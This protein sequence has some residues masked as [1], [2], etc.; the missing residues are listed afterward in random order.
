MAFSTTARV[1]CCGPVRRQPPAFAVAR[2][3]SSSSAHQQ[4]SRRGDVFGNLSVRSTS[5]KLLRWNVAKPGRGGR[6]LVEAA[7]SAIPKAAGLF[8]PANDKDACG[9]G[10]VGELNREPSRQCVTDALEMMLRMSHRGACGCEEN[11]GDGAGCLV[12]MPHDFLKTVVKK[13]CG[14]DLPEPED[15]GVGMCFLPNA[16]KELYAKAKS[17]ITKV[18]EQ[19][20]H[21]VLGWRSVPTD[22][23][24]IGP[25]AL[26]TQPIVEQIFLGNS[27]QETYCHT[28]AEQQFYILRKLIE[29]ELGEQEVGEDECYICSLSSRILV[30]KGQLTPGQVTTYY[31]D[32]Q[33]PDFKTYMTL[34]HSRFSTNTF[35]SWGRSQPMRMIG[36]NG[37][38]NTL[39][40]N[41]NWMRS[42]EGIMKCTQLGLPE[43]V[44]LKMLPLVPATQSDSG[45]F[46][47]V[48]ELLVNSG[49]DLPEAMM[50]MIP[51]AWQNDKLMPQ[52]KQDFYRFHS[53]IMEPWDGPALVAFTDGRFVGAT[54]D[55][56]GLRPG[57]YYLTKDNRVIMASEVGVVDVAPDNVAYKGRLSPGNIFLVDFAEGRVIAD[58][59]MKEKYANKKPYGKWLDAQVA[60]LPDLVE[61][62]PEHLFKVPTIQ[63]GHSPINAVPVASSSKGSAAEAN[64][65]ANGSSN[66]SFSGSNGTLSSSQ[67]GG[68]IGVNASN[69]HSKPGAES[70]SGGEGAVEQGDQL[71]LG[72]MMGTHRTLQPLKA[73]GYTKEALEVQL[74]PMVKAAAEPLG[75]MG[76]DAPLAAM[77]Q[78]PKL[79]YDYFKQMF[80][81][82]TNPPIDPLREKLVTSTRAMIGPEG[83][84]TDMGHEGHAARLELIQPFLKPEELQA[85]KH[86]DYRGWRAKV[87][88]ATWA[89]SEGPDGMEAGLKR[90]CEEADQAIQEGYSYLIMSDRATGEQRVPISSLLA[91]GRVHHHLVSKKKRMLAGL[92]VESGE[93]RDVH[94]MCTLLGYGAD[95]ICPYLAMEAIVA[96]QEDGKVDG[97]ASRL[98]LIENYIKALNA[99][100]L[101]VMSKM[102]IS[103]IASYKGAQIFE[104]LGM[105]DEVVDA[106]FV[107]TASRIAGVGY[108]TLAED[109]MRVHGM[110]YGSKFMS[111]SM[112]DA[113]A[114]PNPGD[115]HW[116][117]G[118][119]GEQ[120]EVHLNDPMAIAKL[121]EAAA[122]NS[123]EAFKEYVRL[124]EDLNE[125]INLRGMLKFKS[126]GAIPIEEVEPAKEIVKRFVTGAMSYGSISLEAHT[127]L[128]IAMNTIGGKSNTGEG[129]ENLRRLLP[130]PDGSRNM[131]RSAIKQIASGRFGVTANYLTNADELQ[132]KIAQ[133]AK[134]GEGGELPGQ[135]VQGDIART[136]ASTPGVGLISP[137]PHHD[138]YSIE[139]LAQLIYDLK[140]SNPGARVSVKL[141]SENNVGVIASGV[142]KGHAD[143]VL[144]SGHDGGTGAA[145]WTSIKSAG[146]PWELGLA[147]THQ[148]LVAN[149]LRGR[150]TLQADG[151]MRTGKDIAVAALLG[152]EEFGFSTAP[153]ITLGCIMMRKCHTNTCPVGVATQDPV[154]R[155]KFAGEP[156]HAINFFFM[157]AE[158]MRE[159]MAAMGFRNVDDMIGRADM[160]EVN[161]D[162]IKKYP[163]L[164][165]INLDKILLPAARLRE[166]VAQRC[167][168]KQDHGLEA[169][170][171]IQLIPQCASALP[172][173]PK[174]HPPQPVYL[175]MPVVNTNRATG[176]T[177]S[178]EVTKKFGEAG[179]PADTIHIKLT[180]H[181]GQSLA[182]WLCS[183][184]TIELEG[185]ANDYVAK[186]LSGGVV[187]VYP[188]KRATF[189]AEENIIVGNVCLYGAVKGEAYFSGMAAERFCVRNSGATAVVEGVGD[190]ACEYMTGGTALIL[191]RTGKN[192]GAGMSGGIAYVYDPHGELPGLCNEDVED[193]LEPLKA[194]EDVSLVRSLLQRHSRYTGSPKAKALL[195]DWTT[196]QAHFVKIFPHEYRRAL[197]EAEKTKKIQDDEGREVQQSGLANKDAFAELKALAGEGG[198]MVHGEGLPT[199]PEPKDDPAE[200]MKH[201]LRDAAEG[202]LVAQRKITWE[203][204]RPTVKAVGDATKLRGFV[205]YGRQS[206]PYRP[207][208]DRL[209]DYGE[210]LG[211]LP[212]QDQEELLHTQAARCMD[213]GTPFCHQTSS[214][215]PLG[216]LIPEWNDLVHKGRWQEALYRLLQTNNFPEFTGRVCPAPCEGSCVLGI[217]EPPVTIKTMEC[218]I[219][220]KGFEMG[221]MV[222]RPPQFRTGKKVAVIGSG[223]AGMAAADQLN[224][225]GHEVTVYERSDRIGGL[226]MYGVPNMKTDKEEV[227]Q[228]RVDLMAQEGVRFV[229]NAH[230]GH[231]VD[232]KDLQAASDAVVLAA[233]ATKPRDLP[234]EGRQSQG[235]HFAMDFLHANTKSLL[236]S[237]LQD[238]KYITAKD[239]NVV[240][241]GGGD[242]GTDC[243]GTSV[244]HGAKNVINL[245]LMGQPPDVRAANNR[246]PYWPRIFRVDYGHAEAALK[247]GSDPRKYNVMSKKFVTD[248]KG[249]V[250]GIEIVHVKWEAS[251]EGGRPNLVELEGTEEVLPADLVL[252]AMGFLG[253]EATLADA[254]GLEL[255]PRSNFK[256]EYGQFATSIEG[257]CRSAGKAAFIVDLG[258]LYFCSCL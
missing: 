67:E 50:M 75:S 218:T 153:L 201:L 140:S 54:L 217:N 191:G 237:N 69:G 66:G 175:E 128:A 188:D 76:N 115:Y 84:V 222:P 242:T 255:D 228:R 1:V 233:G 12:A 111:A 4:L 145:K 107:G 152:A 19:L 252:L 44:L 65:K 38:I 147:E 27:C 149:D 14:V 127:T 162:V 92:L 174:T 220:D 213:C 36:H 163:R 254:L 25:S 95:A 229:V 80:A 177:L 105:A 79:P 72:E 86:M 45:S 203:S 241:I 7:H 157:V 26:A 49:R 131:Q 197:G 32:L 30:Y 35:P 91:C 187:T 99:G 98:D 258:C 171:D 230:V 15:Y 196:S 74:L 200:D 249:H 58:K 248:D 232:L 39:R 71:R 77:S 117:N 256:A 82:V 173:D 52:N 223:P 48:L 124:T 244:R 155:A 70:G 141:V 16:D 5:N 40:G 18:A 112:A 225:M 101:K 202:L 185:D 179:L 55:R 211:R 102:G 114:L 11:T 159:H 125:K 9:V 94:H 210:V 158:N 2:S 28:D 56:N 41:V 116:R 238:G 182:A 13:D 161:Q 186:G 43:D 73:F 17:I 59:E 224:K 123:T 246:W 216:N 130:N 150:A 227:V 198:S 234:I 236:D 156:E 165:G 121:Q 134:P 206:L 47:A 231:N 21:E 192:F 78:M 53:A 204:E 96:L 113:M 110:A 97:R 154:L 68:Q 137:P 250:R 167:V 143:H 212:Q 120:N 136:R 51:E 61:S 8:N 235:V 195:S 251:K 118:A 88:D 219:I 189:K 176:T 139:D 214:G 160:L 169:G 33:Q 37:E 89:V 178:H 104:C 29:N 106:C 34:V 166:N 83:D 253:P 22:S 20:G 81:Q 194:D 87:L 164:A 190:H 245:E 64:G 135:K 57:R 103:T 226:M 184:I 199:P 239:K 209:Q 119:A 243:I 247:Y 172:E 168:R 133:G 122:Q 100:V 138:I 215:C 180:G 6:L 193:D 23:T 170:L 183:G 151:Q 144:I 42:R 31:E 3:V 142:V 181:A 85:F 221:W 240:V 63:S 126:S 205:E 60:T 132:I 146:L 148:T 208:E 90:I 108:Q 10:F 46:D 93:A 24:G 207:I 62:V 109:Q 129:G 257:R